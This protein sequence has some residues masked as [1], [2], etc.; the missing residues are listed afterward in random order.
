MDDFDGYLID[1]SAVD[2]F[3]VYY[4][5]KGSAIQGQLQV[6]ESVSAEI[7]QK[8]LEFNSSACQNVQNKTFLLNTTCQT[9]QFG[10]LK[11][12]LSRSLTEMFSI[13]EGLQSE[14]SKSIAQD[15]LKNYY[16][17]IASVSIINTDPHFS[18]YFRVIR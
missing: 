13:L 8:R 11:S 15:S 10:I 4:D 1:Q 3:R 7:N 5:D 6:V 17:Q 2:T 9:V 14:S 12:G 16:H 18:E